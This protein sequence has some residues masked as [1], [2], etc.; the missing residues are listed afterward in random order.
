[1]RKL[2]LI[3]VLIF[4]LLIGS[5][6]RL[7]IAGWFFPVGILTIIVFGIIHII[8]HYTLAQNDSAL[9]KVD[10][11]LLGI[12]HV[13]YLNLFFFQSDGDDS[14]SY[15]VIEY[16]IG[17]FK[18][19][20]LEQFAETIFLTSFGLYIIIT[21]VL[22]YRLKDNSSNFSKK[23]FKLTI[24]SVLLVIVVPISIIYISSKISELK[25]AKEDEKIGKYENLKRALRNKKKC[26][27]SEAL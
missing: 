16:L 20:E 1:M 9:K 11:I 2:T 22:L 6:S 21:S 8:L 13:L 26:N 15:V 5:L 27:L 4:T 14:R 10:L 3:T 23:K 18:S 24:L 19:F 17:E 12:S 7:A 25:D